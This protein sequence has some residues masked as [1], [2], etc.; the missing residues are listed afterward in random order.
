MGS[1]TRGG[2]WRRGA[3]AAAA[4]RATQRTVPRCEVRIA[5]LGGHGVKLAGTVLSEAAGFHEGLWATQRG[6]YGSATRGGPSRVDV[7]LGSDAITYPARTI[8]M[9]W[10]C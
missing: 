3:R 6:D 1:A 8:P 4:G 10:W 2:R 9:Y 5:G 7:V